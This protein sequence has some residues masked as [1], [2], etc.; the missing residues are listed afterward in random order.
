MTAEVIE[1]RTLLGQEV[2]TQDLAIVVA[3]EATGLNIWGQLSEGGQSLVQTICQQIGY[4]IQ[5]WLMNGANPPISQQQLLRR[6]L[7]LE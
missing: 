6:R 5:D 3:Q 2:I 1:R 4:D 7:G